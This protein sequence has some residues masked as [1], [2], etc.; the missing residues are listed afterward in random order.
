MASLIVEF[1]GRSWSGQIVALDKLCNIKISVGGQ[2]LV[3][4]AGVDL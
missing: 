3:I 2:Q 1:S 4:I